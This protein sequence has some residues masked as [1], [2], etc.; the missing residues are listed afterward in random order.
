MSKGRA[1]VGKGNCDAAINSTGSGKACAKD[2]ADSAEA[3]VGG[4]GIDRACGD[5]DVHD[6]GEASSPSAAAAAPGLGM[7]EVRFFFMFPRR[8][9]RTPK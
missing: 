1:R 6:V 5:E 9:D 3:G 2:A 8:R 7:V 4:Q